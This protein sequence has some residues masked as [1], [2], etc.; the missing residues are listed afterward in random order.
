MKTKVKNIVLIASLALNLTIIGFFGTSIYLKSTSA[1]S[2]IISNFKVKNKTADLQYFNGLDFNI[3]GKF[4]KERNFKRLPSRYKK[5]VRPRVWSLSECSSGISIRFKTNSSVISVKWELTDYIEYSNMNRICSSGLDLYCLIDKK[6]QYVNSAIPTNVE[7]ERLLISDMDTTTKEFLLNLPLYDGIRNIE[8][9]INEGFSISSNS[10]NSLTKKPIVFYGTSVTQGGSAS[11]PGMAYPSII[12]RNLNIET[13]NLG[14]SGNGRFEKSVGHALCEIDAEMYIIDCVANSSPKTIK[15]NTIKLIKQIRE[16]KPNTPILLVERIVECSYFK[17]TDELTFGGSRQD[18]NNQLR[19]SF[20][21]AINIGIKYLYYLESDGLIGYDNEGTVDATHLNDLGM[22]RIAKK[23]EEKI[24][25]ILET[26]KT[27]VAN[28][29][30]K[31]QG[32]LQ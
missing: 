28:N 27:E 23:I 20:D 21:N 11:R 25:E 12:F 26:N 18:Q 22:K 8:I 5:I 16:C 24:N 15:N 14:F 30:Y 3:Q 9:G 1:A 19:K 17:Q 7:N 29:I 13:I 4:H 32:I 31:K 6:W 2:N 10:D